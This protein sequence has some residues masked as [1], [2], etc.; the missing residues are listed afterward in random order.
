[1]IMWRRKPVAS[2]TGFDNYSYLPL[3]TNAAATSAPSV[4]VAASATG[5]AI[6]SYVVKTAGGDRLY[7]NLLR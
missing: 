7:A 1:M 4:S 2:T 3:Y 5:E 6:V